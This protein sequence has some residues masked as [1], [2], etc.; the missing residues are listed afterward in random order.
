MNFATKLMSVFLVCAISGCAS[1]HR[2]CEY[3]DLDVNDTQVCTVVIYSTAN[4]AAVFTGTGGV[5]SA[6]SSN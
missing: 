4:T 2:D 5:V 1:T 3:V 6:T